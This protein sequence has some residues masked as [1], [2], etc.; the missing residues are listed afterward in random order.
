MARSFEEAPLA[1]DRD[2]PATIPYEVTRRAGYRDMKGVF[3]SCAC[4]SE[5]CGQDMTFM[6]PEEVAPVSRY[7]REVKCRARECYIWHMY[8]SDSFGG[9]LQ[10]EKWRASD[11]T[12]VLPHHPMAPASSNTC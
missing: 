5:Q 4:G 1:A 3:L 9:A 11:K 6:I 10:P 2:M 8:S 7:Y 12:G